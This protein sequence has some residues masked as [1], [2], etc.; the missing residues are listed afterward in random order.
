M[1]KERAVQFIND[2]PEFFADRIVVFLVFEGGEGKVITNV[3]DK[4]TITNDDYKL[5]NRIEGGKIV[6]L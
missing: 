6:L 4:V 5:S 2:N 3:P 1:G